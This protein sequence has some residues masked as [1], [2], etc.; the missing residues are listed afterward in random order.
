MLLLKIYVCACKVTLLKL[1]FLLVFYIYIY[2][3]IYIYI[4]IYI[5]L[6]MGYNFV[7][8][9]VESLSTH[10]YVKINKTIYPCVLN[11]MTKKKVSW[12]EIH[13]DDRFN[14]HV[15]SKRNFPPKWYEV[16]SILLWLLFSLSSN[17]ISY[18]QVVSA[19]EPEKSF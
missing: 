18:L 14:C 8:D 16:N 5:L 11:C 12:S 1:A 2:I 13:V 4:Y 15:V 10:Y 7:M 19:V 6:F 17:S 9:K 3:K